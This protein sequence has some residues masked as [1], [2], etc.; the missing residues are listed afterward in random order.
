MTFNVYEGSNNI[1]FALN[2]PNLAGTFDFVLTS[3]YSKQPVTLSAS[4]L[5]TNDRY[6]MLLTTF[7]TG[8][9][10]EH[11]NG[12]YYWDL[13]SGTT[14]I[15]KGLVKIITNPGGE[16]GTVSYNSGASTEE[17]EADVYYRPNY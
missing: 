8:F 14:S 11:K 12:V 10:D 4:V 5:D 1:Q 3:Q 17:R 15:E 13:V 2:Q 16:M 9:G 6:S 7:P